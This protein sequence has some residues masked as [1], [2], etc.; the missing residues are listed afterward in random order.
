MRLSHARLVI[1]PA[2]D[3]PSLALLLSS[4]ILLNV[5]ALSFSS[6]SRDQHIAAQQSNLNKYTRNLPKRSNAIPTA[7][8]PTEEG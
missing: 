6:I 3:Y 4:F 1:T 5:Q 2:F 7:G 8:G